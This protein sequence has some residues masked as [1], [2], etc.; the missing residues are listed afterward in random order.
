M[1]R[2]KVSLQ[3]KAK[4]FSS[5]EDAYVSRVAM[6]SGVPTAGSFVM[7]GDDDDEWGGTAK[8]VTYVDMDGDFKGK[9]SAI[10]DLDPDRD[11]EIQGNDVLGQMLGLMN[12]EQF[13]CYWKH[14][15]ETYLDRGWELEYPKQRPEAPHE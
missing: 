5:G 10:I 12:R 11:I 9:C 7:G 6:F 2:C 13:L 4:Q 8:N 3:V 14:V 1:I 15:T